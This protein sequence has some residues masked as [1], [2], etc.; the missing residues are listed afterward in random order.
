MEKRY[1]AQ[2]NNVLVQYYYKMLDKIVNVI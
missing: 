2:K 1:Y